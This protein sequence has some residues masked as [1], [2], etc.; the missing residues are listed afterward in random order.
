VRRRAAR[1]PLQHILGWEDFRGLRLRVTPDVLIPRPETEL[2]AG[3]A[4]ELLPPPAAGA[5]PLMVDVGTGSGCIACA[6]A[7]ERPDVGVVAV[8]LSPAA[9]AVARANAQRLGLLARVTVASGDLLGALRP[10]RAELV[11]GDVRP[12][13]A[14]LLHEFEHPIPR[15]HFHHP[16]AAIESSAQIG[17]DVYI[18]AHVYVG[19]RAIVGT[20]CTLLAGSIVSADTQ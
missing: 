18:G 11:V 6:V 15:G 8:D 20:R 10:G 14:R 1:E 13:L 12:A 5:R 16:T 7:A 4:L 3:W 9:A 2:L 19:E 17:A